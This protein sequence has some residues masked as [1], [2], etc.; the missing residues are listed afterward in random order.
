MSVQ[1]WLDS[2]REQLPLRA[3]VEA[4]SAASLQ[5]VIH[6][7]PS[8]QG[9]L[10]EAMLWVRL[11][12]LDPSHD[13]VQEGRN[14]FEKYIHGIIHRLE[15]DYWNANYWFRQVRSR[16]LLAGIG[17]TMTE[18]L[19]ASGNFDA[20][21]KAGFIDQDEFSPQRFVEACEAFLQ[22]KKNASEA[23][24]EELLESIGQAEWEAVWK[25]VVSE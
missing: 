20:A 7:N 12:I 2:L 4:T 24:R 13:I 9:T 11:G 8:L 23:G 5:A 16:K 17:S 6:E 21:R 10:V 19:A 25:A 1:T 18:R 22:S 15:G 3:K 14:D